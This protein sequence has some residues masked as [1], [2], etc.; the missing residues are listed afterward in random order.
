MPRPLGGPVRPRACDAA[1]ACGPTS[2]H[3][4]VSDERARCGVGVTLQ[5]S[6]D[7]ARRVLHEQGLRPYRVFIVWQVRGMDRVWTTH[8]ELELLPVKATGLHEMSLMVTPAGVLPDGTVKLRQI[9]PQQVTEDTLR[10]WIDGEAWASGQPDRQWFYEIR[11]HERCEGDGETRRRRF[12]LAGEPELR[13]DHFE[14]VVRLVNSMPARDRDG[15]DA[16][17]ASEV[18]PGVQRARIVP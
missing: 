5:P 9:S 1:S 3:A 8:R 18:I 11:L 16:T 10:G 2:T 14:W 12:M 7:A 13:A 4:A 6:I 15:R 17:V